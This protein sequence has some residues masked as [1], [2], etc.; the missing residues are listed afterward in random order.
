MTMKDIQEYDRIKKI[1]KRINPK[2]M[3]ITFDEFQ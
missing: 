1:F 3:V 2:K